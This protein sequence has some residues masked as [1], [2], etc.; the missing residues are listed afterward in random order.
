MLDFYS[1]CV[2]RAEIT[3]GYFVK[4]K[5]FNIDHFYIF[6]KYSRFF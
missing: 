1:V 3:M 5:S 2:L 4:K 6:S